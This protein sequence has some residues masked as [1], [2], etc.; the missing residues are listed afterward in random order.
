MK[1]TVSYSYRDLGGHPNNVT[2][3]F[4]NFQGAF[5]R[6]TQLVDRPDV[7]HAGVWNI[8]HLG[9]IATYDPM[10][11]Q[12]ASVALGSAEAYLLQYNANRR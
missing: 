6:F 5:H 12:D 9:E 4:K 8:S 7:T 11:G 1:Y 3:K 2:E 10:M